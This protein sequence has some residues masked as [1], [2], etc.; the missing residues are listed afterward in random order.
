M[1]AGI[2]PLDCYPL[3]AI[4]KDD[5]PG[6]CFSRLDTRGKFSLDD[7]I[8]PRRTRNISIL[9]AFLTNEQETFR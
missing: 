6:G 2:V 3:L 4:G 1:G 8:D 7:L 5:Y 9:R